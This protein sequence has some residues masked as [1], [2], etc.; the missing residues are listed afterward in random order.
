MAAYFT[1]AGISDNSQWYNNTLAQTQYQKYIEAVVSRYTTST[2]ILS[3][4]LANEPRCNGCDPS[5]L[6]TWIQSTAQYV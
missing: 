1:Y 5:I 4:E 3:W 2:A 6:Q